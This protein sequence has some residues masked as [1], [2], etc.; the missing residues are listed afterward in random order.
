MPV[1][2][3]VGKKA[4]WFGNVSL[5]SLAQVEG[6]EQHI[7]R[8]NCSQSGACWSLERVERRRSM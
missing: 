7:R 3:S 1:F 8:M 4:F 5:A 6:A 2:V